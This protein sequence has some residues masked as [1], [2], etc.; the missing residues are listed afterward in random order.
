MALVPL[1]IAAYAYASV[2]LIEGFGRNLVASATWSTTCQLAGVRPLQLDRDVEVRPSSGRGLG[3]FAVRRLEPSE[4]VGRYEGEIMTDGD[5]DARCQDG[6]TSGDYAFGLGESG[7]TIDGENPASA[8][9]LRYCNHSVRRANLV[10]GKISAPKVLGGQIVG[11]FLGVKSPIAAGHELF[12]DYGNQYW[13]IELGRN[14][15]RW[16]RLLVDYG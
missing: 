2:A 10:A 1:T 14:R 9:W 15:L 7:W 6:E 12:F 16:R 11:I 8:S 4:L 5:F 3:V 13:D